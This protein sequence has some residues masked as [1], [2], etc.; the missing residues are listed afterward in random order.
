MAIKLHQGGRN[1]KPLQI[2]GLYHP[3]ILFFENWHGHYLLSP[4]FSS[5]GLD[6]REV[7][8]LHRKLLQIKT[9]ALRSLAIYHIVNIEE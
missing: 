7:R 9:T 2:H 6:H 5:G 8:Q 1:L 4:I 3:L